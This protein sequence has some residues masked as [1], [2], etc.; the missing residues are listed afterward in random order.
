MAQAKYLVTGASGQL[1]QSI[2]QQL[3]EMGSVRFAVSTRDP[4]SSAGRALAARGIEVRQADFEDSASVKMA[5]AGIERALIISTYAEN[6][7]RLRQHLN[8]IEAA[9]S[10][11]VRHV[12]YTSFINATPDSLIE[13]NTLVHVPTERALAAS[14]MTYTILRHT[15]YAD[16]VLADVAKTVATGTLARL[17]RP[18]SRFTVIARADLGLPAAKVLTGEEHDG[19]TY[20]LTMAEAVT[21]A[22]AARMIGEVFGRTISY[23][24][25]TVDQWLG[26]LKEHLGFSDAAAQSTLGTMAAIDAGEMAQASPDYLSICGKPARSLRTLLEESRAASV[27]VR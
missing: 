20:T 19:R 25:L 11:S 22:D 12:V 26:V 21:A 10:A 14:G 1:A 23:H 16:M 17:I 5:F 6:H 7:V 8:A 4:S 24:Q 9:K 15:L 27:G 2:I 3:E 18:D 13:H